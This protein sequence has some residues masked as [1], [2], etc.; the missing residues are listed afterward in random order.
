MVEVART[1]MATVT[2]PY[3]GYVGD[4]RPEE[5]IAATPK[6]LA[7]LV[8]RLGPEGLERSYTPGKWS[9]REIVCHL[10]D[11]EISFAFRLRQTLSQPHHVIQPFDQDA[12]AKAYGSLSASAALATFSAIRGWNMALLEAAGP[13]VRSKP[14][15]HPERGDMT[16][17]TIVETMAGHDRNHLRQ[18]ETIAGQKS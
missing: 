12:W 1:Q 14:V 7:E 18:L 16:F 3:A 15:T 10:A 5:V 6:H 11:V 2:N 8:E 9:G 4:L 17:Q 13:E